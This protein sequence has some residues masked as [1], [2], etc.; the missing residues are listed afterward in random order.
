MIRDGRF[1][2]LDSLVKMA[3]R[4]A[5]SSV[6]RHFQ[7]NPTRAR[8]IIAKMMASQRCVALVAEHGNALTGML[9][10]FIDKPFD[11]A[12]DG[13]MA[14]DFMTYAE[15]AGDGARLVK[16]FREWANGKGVDFVLVATSAGV[17]TERTSE[18][19]SRLGTPVGGIYLMEGEGHER[20]SEGSQESI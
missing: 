1:G 4:A 9:L 3:E 16:A 15:R 13:Q 7:F 5:G 2:D 8:Q 11:G 17:D 19:Y 6:Y 12:M 14:T 18:L 20:S 10:G